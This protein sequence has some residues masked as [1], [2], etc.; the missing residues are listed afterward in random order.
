MKRYIYFIRTVKVPDATPFGSVGK[1]VIAL[2]LIVY[3]TPAL[4]GAPEAVV[5]VAPTVCAVPVVVYVPVNPT[6]VP[7][8]AIVTVPLVVPPL[9]VAP[10]FNEPLDTAVTFNVFAAVNEPVKVAPVVL[11][12]FIDELVLA[13]PVPK[14]L[15]LTHDSIAVADLT[16]LY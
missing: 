2:I 15:R 1:A 13:T 8:A 4:K 9:I 10:T 5:A 14:S 12:I 11:V 7:P 16:A 3:V 6:P